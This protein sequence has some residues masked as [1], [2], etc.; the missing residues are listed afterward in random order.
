VKHLAT[1]GHP[2]DECAGSEAFVLTDEGTVEIEGGDPV[3]AEELEEALK[4]AERYVVNLREAKL[5]TCGAPEVL[6]KLALDLPE[7]EASYG[8]WYPAEPLAV[9]LE[10]E[11]DAGWCLNVTGNYEH[12]D[13]RGGLFEG[14]GEFYV[15]DGRLRDGPD[16]GFDDLADASDYEA[17]RKAVAEYLSQEPG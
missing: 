17:C 1:L 16:K 15:V 2:T 3:S 14:G 12:D 8:G 4:R 9:T 13:D 6:K 11:R 10:E 5:I 7:P